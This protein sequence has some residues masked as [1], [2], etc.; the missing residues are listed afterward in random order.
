MKP[1]AT[2]VLLV[3]LASA[4]IQQ[5][6]AADGSVKQLHPGDAVGLN[7]QPEPPGITDKAKNTTATTKS[8]PIRKA[9][10]ETVG[11]NPQPEPPGDFQPQGKQIKASTPATGQAAAK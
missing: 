7:P 1:Y 4:G 10:G 5:A 3:A 2:L 8:N 6:S 11:F 9:G